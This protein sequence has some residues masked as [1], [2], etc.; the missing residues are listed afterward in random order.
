MA[1]EELV[2]A[3]LVD[4]LI[5][6]RLFGFGDGV[7]EDGWYRV[8]QVSVRVRAG[9]A[10]QSHRFAR[11]PV[12]IAGRQASPDELI[13][14]LA[15]D[16]PHVGQVATDLRTAVANAELARAAE[17]DLDGG[18]VLDPLTAERL[19]WARNRPFHPTARA[20]AGWS[21]EE[22]STYGPT[23][24]DP[25]GLDWIAVRADHLRHGEGTPPAELARL[26]LGEAEAH[27]LAAE[28]RP[29]FVLLPVHPWQSRHV[30]PREF[31]SELD[32][33]L[34]LPVAR[35]LG[36]FRP[37]ASLRTL[38]SPD[39]A[40]HVKLP[41]GVATLG[42]TRLLPPRYLDNG[43]RAEL[44]L[45]AALASDPLLRSV[46]T[47]CDERGWVG[48]NGDEFADRP[49]QL[50]AQLRRYPPQAR[51]AVP[52][53]AFASPRLYPHGIRLPE[54]PLPFFRR[55][56]HRFCL[57]ALG[58][59]SKGML[60]E[61]HGQNVAVTL[62]NGMPS[63]FVLRDHDTVRVHPPWLADAGIADPEYRVRQGARQSLRLDDPTELVGYFQT[64]GVQ[65]NLYGIADALARSFGIAER[66]LW[67]QLR[68]ALTEAMDLVRLPRQVSTLLLREPTWPSR[69]V[70]GPLLRSGN[71]PGASMP[72]A[73]GTVPNPL[74]C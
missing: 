51:G 41:L 29:G 67:K 71:S 60:P 64:L 48:W 6:E 47:V 46:V 56:C 1:P 2:L 20:V 43:E 33:G 66:T 23:R 9:G 59:L 54:G 25:L 57:L 13:S 69:H 10:L 15:R 38:A 44:A 35:G 55:L 73:A 36:E 14:H 8:G 50:A 68:V 63:L 49:G 27:R 70:L 17:E 74:L 62:E 11:G 3:D 4:A 40:T 7:L 19:A 34:I 18:A 22:L 28:T 58:F 65:V 52:M 42:A 12:L 39:P 21:T 61:V 53:A 45:R 37:T 32:A 31:A 30:L 5:Q 24:R 26:L 72:A 16:Q